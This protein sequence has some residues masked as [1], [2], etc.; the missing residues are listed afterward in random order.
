[1][2]EF[3]LEFFEAINQLKKFQMSEKPDQNKFP[4]NEFTIIANP[5][6]L[7]IEKIHHYLSTE[8]YWAKGRP[9]EIVEKSF[10]NSLVFGIYQS[11]ELIG[12]ARVVTDYATFGWIADV[13]ILSEFRGIG[14]GKKLVE[15]IFAHP[16]LQGF[17]RWV[18]A[19][20]DAH[21]LYE[22]FGFIALKRPERWMERFDENSLEM[23]DYWKD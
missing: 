16:D 15:M 17:R 11:E 23:P 1:L 7:D 5:V 21:S 20:Q 22:K 14:L 13:F 6:K 8:S 18:L 10:A 12:W 2:L 3:E 9:L 4:T 19:T